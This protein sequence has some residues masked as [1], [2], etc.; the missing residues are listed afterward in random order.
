MSWKK[1]TQNFEKIN[2]LVWNFYEQIFR[3]GLF[4]ETDEG[5]IFMS[6]RKNYQSKINHFFKEAEKSHNQDTKFIICLNIFNSAGLIKINDFFNQNYDKS[7][8]LNKN[9]SILNSEVENRNFIILDA[10][11]DNNILKYPYYNLI[12]FSKIWVDNNSDSP[13]N[14]HFIETNLQECSVFDHLLMLYTKW[15]YNFLKHNSKNTDKK[16][17][18]KK[19][20]LY[21]EFID[22]EDMDYD[23]YDLIIGEK[24]KTLKQNFINKYL[25]EKNKSYMLRL[26]S[27]EVSNYKTY[28][29]NFL[30]DDIFYH[31]KNTYP[32]LIKEIKFI[33]SIGEKSV[34]Q[35]F[36]NLSY[37]FL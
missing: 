29:I 5:K 28:V 36:R 1:K 32:A 31:K 10:K 25:M 13:E 34:N 26:S 19:F 15:L 3:N 18:F 21:Y 14:K 4:R 16:T 7:I 22:P 9:Y 8:N 23:V 24:S 2:M 27:H 30:R 17:L 20:L 6:E 12:Q 37:E 33:R 35:T 11:N